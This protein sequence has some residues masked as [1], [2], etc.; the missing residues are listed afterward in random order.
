MND[1]VMPQETT[2]L[3]LWRW[4]VPL[5]ALSL[6]AALWALDGN[7]RVFLWLNHA[8]AGLG[9]DFWSHVT[10]LGDVV[11]F[12]LILPFCG[13]R[14]QVVWQMLIATL[15]AILWTQSMKAPLGVLRPPAVLDIGQIHLIGPMF[16]N[17]SFPSGH[18]TTIFVLAGVLCLQR[19]HIALKSMILLSAVLVGV[20]RI[21]CGV[22]WPLD[23]LG[24]ALGGWGAAVLG[25]LIGLRW[26]VG[27]NQNAQ[28]VIAL[29]LVAV[30]IWVV[31]RTPVD[32]VQTQ[33]FQILLA[34]AALALSIPAI[35]KL[36]SP[37]A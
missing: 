11:P 17:N 19:F 23:V 4:G 15:F 35:L 22:H 36:F 25:N 27:L 16:L 12:L 3:P 32:F 24:G 31:I 13:R 37:R 14:P 34:L 20:S 8:L 33:I 28:R 7:A 5:T 2:Y 30:A 6:M 21:A 10:I 29:L 1:K 18:T 26:R 9:D